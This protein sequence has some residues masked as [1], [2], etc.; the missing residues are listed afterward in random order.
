MPALDP[1]PE[2]TAKAAV[3]QLR[4]ARR[5]R[6]LGDT[7]WGELAYR[8]YTTALFCLVV[9]IMLAGWVGDR[10]LDAASTQS[11]AR[12]APAWLG[13]LLALVVVM[14]VRSGRRGGPLALE[15]ADVQHLLL[16]PADRSGTLRRP[17]LEVLGYGAMAGAVVFGVIGSLVAQRLPGSN[18]EWV[19]CGALFGVVVVISGLGAALL[20]CSRRLPNWVPLSVSWA[21]LAW[22][23]AELVGAHLDPPLTWI[24]TAPTTFAG[25]LAM[26]PLRSGAV[27]VPWTIV[28]ALSAAFGVAL[29]GGL[30]IEA[31]RRRTQLVGQ[32]RFAVTVQDLR[33]VVL[34]RRQLAAESPRNRRW[35][36]VPRLLWTRQPVLGRDL[37]SVAHWPAIRVA[38]VVVLCCLA[39]LAA[40]GMWSGTTPLMIAAGIATYIAALDAAEPLAEEIDHPTL[41]ASFPMLDGLLHLKHLM[42]PCIVMVLAGLVGVLAAWAVDPAAEVLRLGPVVV[43]IAAPAAVAGAA[44]SIL[45]G[46][47]PDT[48]GTLMTPEVAGPRLVVRTAWPPLVAVLGFAPVIVAARAADAEPLQTMLSVGVFIWVLVGIVFGWVRFRADIHSAMGESMGASGGAGAGGGSGI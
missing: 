5:R 18:M 20:T 4:A 17:S 10:E 37:Q 21:L 7:Q 25:R 24:P 28:A 3:E 32:L 47:T 38:R 46:S 30:S 42:A 12:E 45:S 35:Y 44:V 14:G 8:V 48:A 9:A 23:V 41:T 11:V 33:S 2:A 29:V 34:L 19:A 36:R 40:R 39:G 13:L 16:S 15:A 22:A 26:W 1:P 31:A 6:R 43:A 27:G